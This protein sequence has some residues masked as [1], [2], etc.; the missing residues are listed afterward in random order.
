[1]KGDRN[2]DA[3]L[4]LLRAAGITGFVMDMLT[5]GPDEYNTIKLSEEIERLSG[6][7]PAAPVMPSPE[8]VNIHAEAE[9]LEKVLRVK[10]MIKQL[11]KEI[12]HLRGR[13]PVLP[14][15]DELHECARA[16]LFKD[17]K[18][19]DLFDQLHYFEKHGHWF[20]E[21]PE[22]RQRPFDATDKKQLERKIKNLMGNRCKAADNLK[23]PQTA[24]KRKFYQEKIAGINREIDK[25]KALR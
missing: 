10:S 16:I 17:L 13:L 7:L 24:A 25:L 22:N 21:L 5:D 20:D 6:S 2:Y 15:G 23:K 18:R 19:Q 11:F 8:E 3:G 1:M 9:E 4:A 12:V 14:E